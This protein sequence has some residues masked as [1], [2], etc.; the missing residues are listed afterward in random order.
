M[1]VLDVG[2]GAGDNARILAARGHTVVGI[3]ASAAEAEHARP[4]CQ[5]VLVCDFEA[6]SGLPGLPADFDLVLCSHVLEHL[7]FPGEALVR[8]RGLLRPG[9]L[10]AVAVPNMAH[11][12][13]RVRALQGDWTRTSAGPFDRTHLQ[14]W[15]Y[16]T[17]AELIV[18]SGFDIVQHTGEFSLPQRPLRKLLPGLADALDRRLGAILPNL[19]AGQTLV[20]AQAR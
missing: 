5:Q 20:L 14:F 16:S 3:T 18:E 9:G 13:L 4:H 1:R 11:W 15:S 7:R 8:L 12:R 17:I 2:C 10:L 19:A 6:V